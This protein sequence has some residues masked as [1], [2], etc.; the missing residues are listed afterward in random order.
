MAKANWKM[1]RVVVEVAVHDG[2]IDPV[3]IRWAVETALNSYRTFDA[4]IRSR[5]SKTGGPIR[6]GAVTVKQFNRVVAAKEAAHG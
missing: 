4:V 2:C 5:H 1:E 3:D 6:L